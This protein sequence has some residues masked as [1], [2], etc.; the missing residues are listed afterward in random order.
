MAIP[1]IIASASSGDWDD[2]K[3]AQHT[4]KQAIGGRLSALLEIGGLGHLTPDR[5]WNPFRR[6]RNA[7]RSLN[8]YRSIFPICL[9]VDE[10]A[11]CMKHDIHFIEKPW[12]GK[13]W[14]A[15]IRS[16]WREHHK[17]MIQIADHIVDMGPG[18]GMEGG[19][20]L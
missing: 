16:A 2:R 15:G 10:R 11:A 12:S 4:R 18:S 14:T 1:E 19:R 7:V 6:R 17:E 13:I 9:S 5:P 20:I 3:L 8:R